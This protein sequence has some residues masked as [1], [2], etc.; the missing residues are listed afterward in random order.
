MQPLSDFNAGSSWGTAQLGRGESIENT[1][2]DSWPSG[3]G[4]RW[5]HPQWTSK[6]LQ[7]LGVIL[8]VLCCTVIT[9]LLL[10]ERGHFCRPNGIRQ[11]GTKRNCFYFAYISSHLLSFCLHVS[12]CL[13]MCIISSSYEY[14]LEGFQGT[15]TDFDLLR[16]TTQ[17]D[18]GVQ[19]TR[20]TLIDSTEW[21]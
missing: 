1:K 6:G 8:A 10:H 18:L 9:V 14:D 5:L 20:L 19:G 11:N 17:G 12:F 2:G 21:L 3:R 16:L 4:T 15:R 13:Q 7:P